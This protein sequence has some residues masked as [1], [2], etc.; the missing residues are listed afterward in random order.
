[1]KVLRTFIGGAVLV[2]ALLLAFSGKLGSWAEAG[3][4]ALAALGFW[5]AVAE[6]AKWVWQR[7]TA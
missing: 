7:R 1:M 6:W 2:A 4:Y 3:A 5:L